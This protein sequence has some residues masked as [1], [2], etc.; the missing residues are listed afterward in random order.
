MALTD[1]DVYAVPH[2]AVRDLLNV[3]PELSDIIL[4]AFIARRQILRESGTFT[5]SRVIGSRYSQDTFR[6]TD[7]LAANRMLYTWLDLERD[8]R[9]SGG[10][11]CTGCRPADRH[12]AQI[13]VDEDA[14]GVDHRRCRWARR[15]AQ[16]LD[17]PFDGILGADNPVGH[18][19]PLLSK[20]EPDRGP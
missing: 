9:R 3:S 20:Q 5:G 13:R 2:N 12:A 17:D 11:H 10:S 16:I 14:R 1:T 19:G 7:F 8:A 15:A 18:R 6:I 4:K